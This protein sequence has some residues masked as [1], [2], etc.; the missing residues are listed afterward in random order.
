M[1]QASAIFQPTTP[2]FEGISTVLFPIKTVDDT[3]TIN[4]AEQIVP[5]IHPNS[6]QQNVERIRYEQKNAYNLVIGSLIHLTSA[7]RLHDELV[8]K[9]AAVEKEALKMEIF[10]AFNDDPRYVNEENH[11]NKNTK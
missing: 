7:K 5:E 2:T 4:D 11:W 3:S 9:A 6:H 10:K 1:S 8:D